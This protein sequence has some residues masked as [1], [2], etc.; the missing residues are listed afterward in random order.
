MHGLLD[1][2]NGYQAL[3]RGGLTPPGVPSSSNPTKVES[4]TRAVAIGTL[5]LTSLESNNSALGSSSAKTMATQHWR[6]WNT[7][8]LLGRSC[9][10]TT[11]EFQHRQWLPSA[12]GNNDGYQKHRQWIPERSDNNIHGHVQTATATGVGKRSSFNT[13]G[14]RQHR[15]W[16][17]ARF[18][19]T[20]GR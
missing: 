6:P 14:S 12:L 2:A 13:T 11:G 8:W 1:T 10:N 4:V 9:G 5:Q 18:R 7:A 20:P 19:P 15:Q 3:E 17:R 16:E